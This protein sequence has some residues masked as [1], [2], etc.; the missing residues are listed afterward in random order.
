MEKPCLEEMKNEAVRLLGVAIDSGC[1]LGKGVRGFLFDNIKEMCVAADIVFIPINVV[2]FFNSNYYKNHILDR[3]FLLI[4][5]LINIFFTLFVFYA[6][7]K[8]KKSNYATWPA[9]ISLVWGVIRIL[10]INHGHTIPFSFDIAALVV[11]FSPLLIS[12]AMVAKKNVEIKRRKSEF[13]KPFSM[14]YEAIVKKAE[15]KGCTKAEVDEISCWLT[16]YSDLTEL[17]GRTFGEFISKAPEWNPHAEYITRKISC[18]KEETVD[19]RMMKRMLQLE[20]LIDELSDGKLME[21]IKRG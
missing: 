15:N 10:R 19:D 5:L 1:G 11:I 7:A 17:E 16:G 14:V 9:G 18:V 21:K 13:D 12:L 8:G 2:Y 3:L 6:V 4:I 20:K